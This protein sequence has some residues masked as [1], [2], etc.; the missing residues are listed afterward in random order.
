[1]TKTKKRKS[2]GP[3]DSNNTSSNESCNLELRHHIEAI[4]QGLAETNGRIDS[5]EA[6]L[7]SG[8]AWPSAPIFDSEV[9]DSEL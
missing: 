9:D 3:G 4:A 7:A 5:L 1:M 6:R 2:S 8:D